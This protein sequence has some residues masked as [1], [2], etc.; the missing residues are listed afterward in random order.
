LADKLN[1]LQ[2]QG[3]KNHLLLWLAYLGKDLPATHNVHLQQLDYRN[4]LLA[5]DLSAKGFD[6][7]DSLAKAL[8][9]D[10]VTVKQ[11]NV[12]SVGTDVKGTLIIT[13]NKS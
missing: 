9:Q 6:G 7:I 4:G 13:E 10:G 2:N 3:N 8:T 5:L 11:Q 1:S 12:A